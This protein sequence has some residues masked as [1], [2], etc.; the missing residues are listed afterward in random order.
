MIGKWIREL[1]SAGFIFACLN[2]PT[3]GQ[4]YL[5]Y[6]E[7]KY[8]GSNIEDCGNNSV[9][10]IYVSGVSRISINGKFEE[11]E[12]LNRASEV[13]DN[14]RAASCFDE[15][16]LYLSG[17]SNLLRYSVSNDSLEVLQGFQSGI[18][19]PFFARDTS[20]HLY[21]NSDMGIFRIEKQGSFRELRKITASGFIRSFAVLD[22]QD[23]LVSTS[24]D[25]LF[26]FRGEEVDTLAF[27][28]SRIFT[29]VFVGKYLVTGPK[30]DS[31]SK[32]NALLIDGTHRRGQALEWVLEP[33]TESELKA[34]L[35][36]R[37]VDGKK[38]V[39]TYF[40]DQ[41]FRAIYHLEQGNRK[42]FAK[43]FPIRLGPS[44]Q[45]FKVISAPL[46]RSEKNF[47]LTS[48]GLYYLGV[49]TFPTH[50]AGPLRARPQTIAPRFPYLFDVLGRS[51]PEKF[52]VLP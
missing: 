32:E 14:V 28:A 45:Q 51:Q 1:F 44:V 26:H 47:I 40:T 30:N 37:S 39:A 5:T 15:D 27:P 16:I 29:N 52:F 4:V 20:G 23:I 11:K 25:R 19:S 33:V 17:W 35:E 46:N 34:L 21:L 10:H 24:T 49:D 22:S 42:V 31:L 18:I 12:I 8:T 2:D 3:Y 50:V 43:T 13:Y 36:T 6:T 9:L 41:E 38:V 7:S 48:H